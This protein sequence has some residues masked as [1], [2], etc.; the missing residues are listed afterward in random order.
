MQFSS[1]FQHFC[2]KPFETNFVK[3]C[4]V[5]DQQPLQEFM[6]DLEA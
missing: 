4:D 2:Q 5:E 1:L 3:P 6:K